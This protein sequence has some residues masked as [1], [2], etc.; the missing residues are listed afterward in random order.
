MHHSDC[1]AVKAV[2]NPR[3]R[4][5]KRQDYKNPDLKTALTAEQS[6]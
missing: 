5:L 4:I 6:L 1:S 3:M 2:L